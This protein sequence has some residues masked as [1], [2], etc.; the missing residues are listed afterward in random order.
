MR[1]QW[2]AGMAVMALAA[3]TLVIGAPAAHAGSKGRKNTTLGL[4]ALA[5]H[6]LLTG[7]TTTGLAAAAGTA[8]AYKRYRDSRKSERRRANL[9][10]NSYRNVSANSYRNLRAYDYGGRAGSGRDASGL[11]RDRARYGHREQAG[12]GRAGDGVACD[13]PGTRDRYIGGPVTNYPNGMFRRRDYGE[14]AR[15][16]AW[17]NS[18]YR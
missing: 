1:K 5:A 18:P 9:S 3:G 14:M 4:G 16:E 13:P 6:Q 8:Y 15:Q 12:I 7:R 17:R 2:I 10:A 11:F